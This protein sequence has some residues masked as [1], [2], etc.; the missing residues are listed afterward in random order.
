VQAGLLLRNTILKPGYLALAERG[1]LNDRAKPSSTNVRSRIKFQDRFK[2]LKLA[3]RIPRRLPQR[4]RRT[5]GRGLPR[6]FQRRKRLS[7]NS[8]IVMEEAASQRHQ[9]HRDDRQDGDHTHYMS[10]ATQ[11]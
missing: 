3:H 11:T 4:Q 8:L 10:P 7:D 1:P 6:L 5:P 9:S 2:T